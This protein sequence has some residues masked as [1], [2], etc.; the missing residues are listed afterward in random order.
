MNVDEDNEIVFKHPL[1]GIE[2]ESTRDKHLHV[3]GKKGKKKQSVVLNVL[4]IL[5]E[6][7]ILLRGLL[8]CI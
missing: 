3:Q 1:S 7:V 2:G 4:C 8:F 5:L 6:N